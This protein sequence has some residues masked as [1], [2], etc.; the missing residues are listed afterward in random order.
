VLALLI[1]LPDRLDEAMRRRL[2]GLAL[3]LGVFSVVWSFAVEV[4]A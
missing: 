1:G 3:H 2:A 4:R